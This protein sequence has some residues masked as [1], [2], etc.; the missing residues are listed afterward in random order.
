MINRPIHVVV[1]FGFF[2]RYIYFSDW[3]LTSYIGRIGL[4]GLNYS[5]VITE[6]LGW[7]NGISIDYIT[8]KIWWIDAHM[9]SIQ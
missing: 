8:N 2:Y 4:D 1:D 3:G 7:P 6:K 9:D 5:K